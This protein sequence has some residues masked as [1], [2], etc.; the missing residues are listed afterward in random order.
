MSI[1][2]FRNKKNEVGFIPIIAGLK[3]GTGDTLPLLEMARLPQGGSHFSVEVR[4]NS[5]RTTRQGYQG[6]ILWFIETCS[7]FSSDSL[8]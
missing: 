8:I 7:R 4:T 3:A 5:G 6:H 1:R 2:Y